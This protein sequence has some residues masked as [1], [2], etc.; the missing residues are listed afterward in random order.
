VKENGAETV[1]VAAFGDSLQRVRVI[2]TA[3]VLII[4]DRKERVPSS[5]HHTDHSL[6]TSEPTARRLYA[7]ISTRY[8]AC[9]Y[10]HVRLIS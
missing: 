8:E 7:N 6:P 3:T 5:T 10:N 4:T 1:N 9:A 2:R